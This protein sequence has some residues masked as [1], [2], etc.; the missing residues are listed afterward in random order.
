MATTT[1]L[2]HTPLTMTADAPGTT[3]E[4]PPE[5]S[6]VF[7]VGLTRDYGGTGLFDVD[8]RVPPESMYGLVGPN[9]AGKTT[10]LSI[11]N[12]MRRADRGRVEV[13]VPKSR[14]AVCPDVPEFDPW[15]SAFETVD[16][17]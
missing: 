15:L 1:T 6:V 8:L 2:P 17:V 5:D 12:G 9:G 11:I 3:S 7:S 4:A 16:P 10:L 14:I 13:R